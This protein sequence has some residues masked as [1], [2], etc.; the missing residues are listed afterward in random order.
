MEVVFQYSLSYIRHTTY[1]IQYM[2]CFGNLLR[3][4][5]QPPRDLCSWPMR[6]NSDQ[7]PPQRG[8]VTRSHL[9][10]RLRFFADLLVSQPPRYYYTRCHAVQIPA[11]APL[12]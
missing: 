10:T 12:P 1:D 11:A 5:L 2:L 6:N 7:L 4:Q 8:L 9:S 3:A